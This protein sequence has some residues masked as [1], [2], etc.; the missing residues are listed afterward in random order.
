MI[1]I[2]EKFNSNTGWAPVTGTAWVRGNASAQSLLLPR[3]QPAISAVV[4]ELDNFIFGPKIVN[5]RHFFKALSIFKH[6]T[7]YTLHAT[8]YTLHAFQI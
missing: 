3:F 4:V 2:F 7:C 5:H 8:R 6:L 1:E